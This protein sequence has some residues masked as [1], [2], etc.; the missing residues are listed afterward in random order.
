M[1]IIILGHQGAARI[2]KMQVMTI[3][4]P[5]PSPRARQWRRPATEQGMFE[6][7][8]SVVGRYD[9]EDGDEDDT[10]EEEEAS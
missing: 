10:D 7:G 3:R 9:R 5:I 8:T 4:C 2:L 6:V 1:T